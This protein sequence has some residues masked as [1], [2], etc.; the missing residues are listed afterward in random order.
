MYCPNC[1]KEIRDDA[2]FCGFCGKSL[3]NT[4]NPE[5]VASIPQK[6]AKTKRPI[7]VA[8]IA[9]LVIVIVA[10]ILKAC[11]GGSFSIEGEWK[12]TGAT[13]FGQ[14]Q[15]GAIVVFDGKNCNFYSP[16]DTY[17]FYKSNGQYVLD[18]TGLLFAENLSFTVDVIDRNHITITNGIVDTEL[19]RVQSDSVLNAQDSTAYTQV[20]TVNTTPEPSTPVNNIETTEEFERKTENNTGYDIT[21]HINPQGTFSNGLLWIKLWQRFLYNDDYGYAVMNESGDIVFFVDTKEI[22]LFPFQEDGFAYYSIGNDWFIIDAA[23]NVCYRT[24]NTEDCIVSICG[25]GDNIFLLKKAVS[26]YSSKGVYIS[27]ITPYGEEITPDY[28]I[29]PEIDTNFKYYGDGIFKTR[30]DWS[31]SDNGF[32][33]A[34]TCECFMGGASDSFVT[35]FIDGTAWY[36]T[37]YEPKKLNYLVDSSVFDSEE[38]YTQWKAAL[39]DEDSTVFSVPSIEHPDTVEI[40]GTM[41]V[42]DSDYYPYVLKGADGNDYF[43]VADKSGKQ[44]YDPIKLPKGVVTRSMGAGYVQMGELNYSNGILAYCDGLTMYAVKPS[45]EIFTYESDFT[46]ENFRFDGKYIYADGIVINVADDSVIDSITIH[47]ADTEE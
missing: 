24:Q 35:S 25:H 1:R 5:S 10:V 28:Q 14:A 39:S 34:N 38:S 15:P 23:G 47:Y 36:Q 18:I 21:Y 40:I 19:T 3:S 6:Q 43:T 17:A 9:A 27:Q 29:D 12:S 26:S 32:Y 11:S 42:F 8:V 33:N 4:N 31:N 13:G 22:E 37:T 41:Y 44:Q 7:W 2:A 20:S 16:S 45:G 30:H 46:I